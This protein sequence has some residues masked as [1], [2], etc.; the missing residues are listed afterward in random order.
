[1]QD[2][3]RPLAAAALNAGIGIGGAFID[4]ALEDELRMIAINV[5]SQVHL[6]KRIVPGMVD[7]RSGRILFTSSLSATTPTPYETVYGPT[8]AFVYS[9]AESLREE[10][11]GTGVTVTALLPGATDSEF[12]QRAGMGDTKFGDN[13]WK[14]SRELVARKGFDALMAGRDHV[15][16][17]DRATW[18]AAVINKFLPERVKAHRQ[19][20][21]ARP[22]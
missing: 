18:R 7:A 1:M 17:G 3:G 10:L 2:T 14:N 6:A 12:H 16:G 22:S 20:N 5:T 4:T 13:S 19:G 11:L 8:Q 21:M 9:F 15:I